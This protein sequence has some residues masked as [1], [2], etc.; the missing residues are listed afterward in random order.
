MIVFQSVKVHAS[1]DARQHLTRSHVYSS[2]TIAARDVCVFLLVHMGIGRNVH[3]TTKSKRRKVPISAHEKL[4][5]RL[6]GNV[7]QTSFI[8][9]LICSFFF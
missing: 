7:I 6:R 3:A 2:A 9:W 5:T 4:F 1:I 8:V